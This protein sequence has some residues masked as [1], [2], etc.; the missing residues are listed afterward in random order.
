MRIRI[1]TDSASD[2][3]QEEAKAWGVEVLPL[4]TIFGGEEF[5][6]G[7]TMDHETFFQRL[8][9][10]D[11]MPTTSQ[12]SPYEYGLVFEEAA[13]AGDTAVCIT[14]SS[15]LSGCF[16][17]ASIAA[18]DYPGVILPVD[19][20]TVCVGQRILVQLAAALRDE[21]RSAQEIAAALET[22]KRN[23]RLIALLDTL[24]YLKKGGRISAAAAIAGSLLSIKPV[25]AVEHGEVVVLGK[26][27]GSKNG[28]NMLMELVQKEGGIR[29][30]R[31]FCLAYSGL[32]DR[33]LQ[34]YIADSAAL[35]QGHTE[36][37]PISTIG[38]TIGT[39][40]G[41]GAIA[42]AFFAKE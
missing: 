38:S 24:E 26:A 4:K 41:P 31:P 20:A 17:S 10:S 12:L 30:D 5:L 34:K 11:V 9:E 39:H 36:A 18:E 32:S 37:L 27:R 35:Y 33:L 15:K 42:A 25:I 13:K 28:S 2:I 14:V 1:I 40:V 29:F 19:S 16:Q 6:D 8:I 21:G 7:V 3:T 22:E 23:I